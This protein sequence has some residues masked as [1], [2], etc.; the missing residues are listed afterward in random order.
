MLNKDLLEIVNNQGVP[1]PYTKTIK[2]FKELDS[3]SLAYVYFMV[4]YRSPYSVYEYAERQLEIKN[5]I[6]DKKWSP[7]KALDIACSG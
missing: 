4:D 7:T 6:F 1:T 5:S 3:K 2:E